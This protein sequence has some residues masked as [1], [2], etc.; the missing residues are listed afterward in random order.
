MCTFSRNSVWNEQYL[1]GVQQLLLPILLFLRIT[2]LSYTRKIG[3]LELFVVFVVYFTLPKKD[4]T[5]KINRLQLNCPF[6]EVILI[7]GCACANRFLS[8]ASFWYYGDSSYFSFWWWNSKSI[9]LNS[10][11][12]QT[13]QNTIW[14]QKT[15]HQIAVK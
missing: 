7:L 9:Y 14:K 8:S 3:L 6:R 10:N 13:A 15:V 4:I 5:K 12:E 11:T 2:G 1:N